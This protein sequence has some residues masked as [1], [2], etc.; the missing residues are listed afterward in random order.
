MVNLRM[1]MEWGEVVCPLNL[2]LFTDHLQH[3]QERGKERER[4]G[5]RRG[6]EGEGG[7]GRGRRG[8]CTICRLQ[9]THTDQ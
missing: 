2:V 5:R 4:R 3:L 9:F 8:Q 7:R 6:G 1:L